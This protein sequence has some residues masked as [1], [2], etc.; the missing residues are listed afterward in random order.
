MWISIKLTTGAI[1]ASKWPASPVRCQAMAGRRGWGEDSIYFDHSGEVLLAG[2]RRRAARPYGV[3]VR[4]LESPGRVRT[5]EARTLR[6]DDVDLE[7]DPDA[8]P[9]VPPHVDGGV[10]YAPMATPRRR[11]PGAVSDLRVGAQP[12]SVTFFA[13]SNGGTLRLTA[14]VDSPARNR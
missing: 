13:R 10:R 11:S 1:P 6:W 5:E 4:C 7:G 14:A 2:H 8:D 3:R 12:T 9:P